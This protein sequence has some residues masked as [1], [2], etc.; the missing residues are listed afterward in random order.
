MLFASSAFN[1][2]YLEEQLI[3]AVTTVKPEYSEM[4]L[5]TP[6]Q[7]KIPYRLVM[8]KYFYYLTTTDQ[9]DKQKVYNAMKSY[10]LSKKDAIN[11]LLEEEK[12]A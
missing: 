11:Y 1:F 8:N 12:T 2:D 10:N 3:R 4:F 7:Q 6:E 5:I 9:D